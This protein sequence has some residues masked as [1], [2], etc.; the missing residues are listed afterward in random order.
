MPAAPR[1]AQPALTPPP[2]GSRSQEVINVDQLCVL[3]GR[4]SPPLGLKG[5]MVSRNTLMQVIKD[6][7][8]PIRQ[9]MITYAAP[10]P[11]PRESGGSAP[12]PRGAHNLRGARDPRGAGGRYEE[13]FEAFVKRCLTGD[14]NE[15][16]GTVSPNEAWDDEDLPGKV[17]R[18]CPFAPPPAPPRVRASPSFLVAIVGDGAVCLSLSRF[19]PSRRTRGTS[20]GGAS[21][22]RKTSPR[23]PF[24]KRTATGVRPRSRCAGPHRRRSPLSTGTFDHRLTSARPAQPL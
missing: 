22:P 23:A 17:R 24:R 4:L 2:V 7:Q 3:I 10:A 8:I 14:L 21:R 1:A 20:A 13:T 9:N 11:I 18:L 5:K 12:G 19:T 15:D 6:L 16:D